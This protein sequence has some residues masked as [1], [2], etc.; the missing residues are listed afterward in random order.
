MTISAAI[1][2]LS[3]P[4][5]PRDHTRA[6]LHR[7]AKLGAD[8]VAELR[9]T[10]LD[11][12]REQDELV[13]LNRG[14]REGELTETVRDLVACAVRGEK[15]SAVDY[16]ASGAAY[17]REPIGAAGTDELARKDARSGRSPAF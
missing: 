2:Q 10:S 6:R 9:N 17:R 1:D 11:S 14:A 15:V 13:F 5:A 4:A 3:K 7:E 16:T 12:A 8:V